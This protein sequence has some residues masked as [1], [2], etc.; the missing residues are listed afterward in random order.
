[1]PASGHQPPAFRGTPEALYNSIMQG[2]EPELAY[3]GVLTAEALHAGDT[4]EQAAAR[5]ERYAKAFAE[6]DR[7]YA[8]ERDRL[9]GE[10][11]AYNRA[12]LADAEAAWG[13]RRDELLRSLDARINAA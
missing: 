1:M 4:P 6:F 2:I 5:Q 10:Q 11:H 13:T 12:A 8:A 3:P 9:K 7:R